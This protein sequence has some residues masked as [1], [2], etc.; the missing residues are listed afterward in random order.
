MHRRIVDGALSAL[1]QERAV[2]F[3]DLANRLEQDPRTAAF[4]NLVFLVLRETMAL[5]PMELGKE[6][7]ADLLFDFVARNGRA[8]AGHLYD[9]RFVENPT[10]LR[11]VTNEM[12][13]EAIGIVLRRAEAGIR[14]PG[15]AT[16]YRLRFPGDGDAFPYADPDEDGET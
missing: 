16:A 10:F 12:V 6:E 3:T 7:T 2:W 11:H 13:S 9:R 5:L 1:P 8:L 4:P 15:R 14:P